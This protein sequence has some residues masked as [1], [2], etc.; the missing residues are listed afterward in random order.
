M[1]ILYTLIIFYTRKDKPVYVPAVIDWSK[2]NI[3]YRIAYVMWRFIA[4]IKFG[5]SLKWQEN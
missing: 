2:I 5:W 1:V 4:C 3:F